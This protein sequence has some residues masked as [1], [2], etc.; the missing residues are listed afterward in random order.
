M[1]MKL[2]F[3]KSYDRIEWLFL[4]AIMTR[5]GFYER[6]FKLIMECVIFV[7]YSTTNVDEVFA[8]I[9]PSRDIR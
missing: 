2:D 6:W 4:A 1:A 8:R 7:K 3:I 9:L 5:M